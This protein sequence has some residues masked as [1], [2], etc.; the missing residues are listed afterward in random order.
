MIIGEVHSPIRSSCSGYLLYSQV[1]TVFL[2]LQ[3][4]NLLFAHCNRVFSLDSL[5]YKS[6][7]LGAQTVCKPT[8]E[9]ILLSILVLPPRPTVPLKPLSLGLRPPPAM[10]ERIR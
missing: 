10:R 7:T 2:I 9:C 6:R 8:G 5:S 1:Y 3:L 4:H